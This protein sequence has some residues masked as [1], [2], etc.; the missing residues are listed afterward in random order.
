MEV[1]I[2][3]WLMNVYSKEKINVIYVLQEQ[4]GY[5]D[6]NRSTQICNFVAMNDDKIRYTLPEDISNEIIKK[7]PNVL[8]ECVVEFLL[9]SYYVLEECL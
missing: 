8:V 3:K 7:F 9:L 6:Y 4:L 2:S 1:K 5:I